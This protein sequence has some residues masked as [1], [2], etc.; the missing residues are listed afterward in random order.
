[1][2]VLLI[3]MPFSFVHT[4]SLGLTLLK[5]ELEERG[6]SCDILYLQLPFAKRIGNDLYYRIAQFAPRTLLGEWIFA[7]LLFDDQLPPERDYIDHILRT[8]EEDFDDDFLR[9][10]PGLR[11]EAEFYIKDCLGAIPLANYD[12][13]GFTSTFAQNVSSLVLAKKIKEIAPDK[14]IVFGGANC[15]DEMGFE[16]HSNFPF[17]DFICSGESDRLFPALVN[18]LENGGGFEDLPGLIFRKYGKSL[19]NGHFAP[20]IFDLDSIPLPDF[21]DYFDQLSKS[22]LSIE[23]DQISLPIETSRGCWWGAKSHCVFCGLNDETLVYRSKNEE[24]VVEEF[25]YLVERYPAFNRIDAVDKILDMRYFRK[26]IPDLIERKLGLNIFYFVKAN[27]TKDQIKM[28]DKAGISRIQPGIESLDS[29]VLQLMRKGTTTIQNIQLLKWATELGID[30]I[31]NF[32]TGFPGEDPDAY[33]KMAELIPAITHLQPPAGKS[34]LVRLDRFSPYFDAPESFGM[35]NVRA[36]ASYSYVYPFPASSLNRLA[37]FFD[38]E[39]SHGENPKDYT[40]VLDQAIEDWNR[41]ENPGVLLTLRNGIQLQVYDTRPSGLQN[42][43]VLKG[44]S[45]AV[46]EYCEEGRTFS[47]ILKYIQGR[48]DLCSPNLAQDLSDELKVLLDWMVEK[49]LM[50]FCDDRYLSLAL[51]MDEPAQGFIDLFL[52]QF[53]R[54][55]T[56]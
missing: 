56:F 16:L 50:L 47:A 42:G 36:A 23:A 25:S 24:R 51:S 17:I 48:K 29:S 19:M 13:F 20:P 28:L 35:V 41:L 43:T 34:G 53:E 44:Y 33:Q 46:Y 54:A 5:G 26:V 27:L 31:W 14:M 18:K 40:R 55:S 2:K 4:P 1:M 15:E 39:Y 49:R 45:K 3:T 10:L 8:S 7:H 32:I 11:Q 38:F 12:I 9:L 52:T 21:D 30:T 6:I 37:Y 22:G